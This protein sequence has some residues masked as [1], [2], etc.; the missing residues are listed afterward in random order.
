[1]WNDDTLFYARKGNI[2]AEWT[3]VMYQDDTAVRM[4]CSKATG[5]SNKQAL[6]KRSVRNQ[7]V[8][9]LAGR[10]RSATSFALPL[11]S[12]AGDACCRSSSPFSTLDGA[13]SFSFPL[14]VI[15]RS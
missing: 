1:M 14:S 10:G 11:L 9:V 15:I 5:Q 6:A 13:R 12:V 4:P 3:Q 7:A 2:R 8:G